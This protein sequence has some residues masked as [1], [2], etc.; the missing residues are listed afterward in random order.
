MMFAKIEERSAEIMRRFVKNQEKVH[1]PFLFVLRF[2]IL[3]ELCL[4]AA[5]KGQNMLAKRG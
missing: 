3:M 4:F 2:L 1:L 5:S